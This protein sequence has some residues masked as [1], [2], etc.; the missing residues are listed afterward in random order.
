MSVGLAREAYSLPTQVLVHGVIWKSKRG[1][2]LCVVQ[3]DKTEKAATKAQGTVKVAVLKNDSKSHNL[4]VTS[5]YDQKPF[6]ML[7]HSIE[8]IIWVK[9]EKSVQSSPPE[10]DHAHIPTI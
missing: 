8:E 6:Y 1:V 10:V 5:C 7:S 3:G 2:P 9:H 4:I